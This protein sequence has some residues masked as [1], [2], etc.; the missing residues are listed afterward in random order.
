[1]H[2]VAVVFVALGVALAFGTAAQ[3]QEVTADEVRASFAG[4]T[5][6]QIEGAGYV[7]EELVCIDAGI[8]PPGVAA[9][10]GVPTTAG[11]GIH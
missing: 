10:L 7:A 1:M 8:L 4:L 5:V 9:L 11:M 2:R 3:A 6:A